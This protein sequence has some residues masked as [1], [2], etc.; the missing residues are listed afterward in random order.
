MSTRFCVSAAALALSLC[1]FPAECAQISNLNEKRQTQLDVR[2]SK[3]IVIQR[4]RIL[5]SI[6]VFNLLNLAG[7]DA[8]TV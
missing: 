7:I 4:A 6:D 8:I 2:V 1:G 5:G 3:R